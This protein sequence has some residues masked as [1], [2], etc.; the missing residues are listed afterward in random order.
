MVLPLIHYDD[1]VMRYHALS[2]ETPVL[3]HF[4]MQVEPGE[5]IAIIGPS[6][7]G[8]STL[9]SLA[10]GLIHPD[11]GRV[12][13]KGIEITSPPNDMGYML[14]RDH[15]FPWLTIRENARIGLRVRKDASEDS[16]QR[17]DALL[18]STGLWDFR[19]RFPAQL[20][21]G[22]RQRAALVRTLAVKPEFLLL[23]EPFS[24]LDSQTRVKISDEVKQTIVEHGCTALLVTH[25]IS[26]AVSMATRV[27]VL[28][29]RPA[30]IKSEHKI[31]IDGL[32]LERREDPL[33][34]EYFNLLWKELDVHVA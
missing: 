5:F 11:E 18:Q 1:I 28:S 32:P 23:D 29:R 2:G 17:V 19:D 15:L 10:A 20:S 13:H 34:K 25:D 21:G 33:F 6:G 16:L 7:C 24:A 12:M 9:L 8:K 27:V 14:Q 4:S 30:A 31:E 26:E 22:M 3:N